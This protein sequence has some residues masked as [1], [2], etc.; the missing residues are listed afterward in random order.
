[1]TNHAPQTANWRNIITESRRRTSIAS[2]GALEAWWVDERAIAQSPVEIVGARALSGEE[3]MPGRSSLQRSTA[4]AFENQ[5]AVLV[6][7]EPRNHFSEHNRQS[8]PG[9]L[10]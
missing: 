5:R 3:C 2:A 1:M 8:S 10:A 7:Q 9:S 6:P 4:D